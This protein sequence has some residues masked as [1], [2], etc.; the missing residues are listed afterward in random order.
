MPVI[1]KMNISSKDFNLLY[2][3]HVLY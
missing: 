2:L 3:F 1:Q